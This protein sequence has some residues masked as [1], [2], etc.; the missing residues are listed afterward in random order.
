MLVLYYHT[1]KTLFIRD[2]KFKQQASIDVMEIGLTKQ[3]TQN[4]YRV[5][6]ATVDLFSFY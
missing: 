5:V 6:V 4:M 3:K 2:V 1:F